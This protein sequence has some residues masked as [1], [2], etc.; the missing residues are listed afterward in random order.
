MS[1]VTN[2]PNGIAT[3]GFR[4]RAGTVVTVAPFSAGTVDTGLDT[5]LFAVANLSVAG[6][7][8]S[9]VTTASLPGGG[10]VVFNVYGTVAAAAT[11]AGTVHYIAVGT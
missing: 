6:T 3:E 5:V 9:H 4:F 10:T 11:V 1:N 7:G 8:A 2:F